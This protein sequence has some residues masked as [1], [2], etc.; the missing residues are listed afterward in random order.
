MPQGTIGFKASGEI[1]A[2]ELEKEALAPLRAKVEAREPLRVLTLVDHLHEDPRAIWESLKA[3]AEFGLL[4]RGSWYRIAVV[5]D[6]GWA[7]RLSKMFG[8]AAPGELRAFEESE[9]EAAKAW[10]ASEG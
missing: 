1:T 10:L 8:W 6:L 2:E 9:L 7:Q 5:S 4:K 3:D